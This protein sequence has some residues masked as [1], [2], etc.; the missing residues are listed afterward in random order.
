PAHSRR[1]REGCSCQGR[2][3]QGR[4]CGGGA[5]ATSG[6]GV[7][8][9]LKSLSC[10]DKVKRPPHYRAAVFFL[11]IR[12][13]REASPYRSFSSGRSWFCCSFP[14]KPKFAFIGNR[15]RPNAVYSGQP[16]AVSP[17]VRQWT[18]SWSRF[19]PPP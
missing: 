14:T 11:F 13:E 3:R 9:D 16:V 2:G 10:H 17:I 6:G 12:L 19:S 8:L 7:G 4:R 15:F 5:G 1:A 18:P